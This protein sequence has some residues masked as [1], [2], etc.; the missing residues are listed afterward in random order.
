DPAATA[1]R[2]EPLTVASI[3]AL[4]RQRFEDEA[5][6]E[7]CA[8][9]EAATR[10]NPLFVL[11]LLDTVAREG[12]APR[13]DQAHVLLELGPQ[14]VGRAVAPRRPPAGAPAL[15]GGA[16]TLGAA[17]GRRP[18]PALARLEPLPAARAAQQ[19]VRSDLLARDDP[20]EFFHPVVRTAIYEGLDAVA[21]SD[22]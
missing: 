4:A 5:D 8:A 15:P 9:V 17:P 3:A 21:R 1:I 16:A 14:V 6:A 7:F 2:P 19:L 10:G 18:A 11:A 12:V 22:G 13:S 20:V